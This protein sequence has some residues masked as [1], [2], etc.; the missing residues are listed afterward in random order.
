MKRSALWLLLTP[1]VIAVANSCGDGDDSV[2]PEPANRAP[3]AIGAVPPIETAATDTVTVDVAGYFADPDGDNLEYSATSS[4]TAVVTASVAASVVSLVAGIEKGTATVSVTARDPSG[5][6]ATQSVA[7]TVVGKPGF[8]QVVLDYPE[9]DVGALVLVVHGPTLDSL[10]AQPNLEAYDVSVPG[11]IAVFIAGDIPE[12]DPI[13]TF[14]T[15]DF[16]ESGNY[17]G[18]VPQAAG[19]DYDQRNVTGAAVRVVPGLGLDH[20]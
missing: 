12:S 3:T 16:T 19:K 10:K 8:L 13:L 20:P 11:G 15:E 9:S 5:L 6:T 2:V 14:W 17:A 18:S 1:G 4:N 7:V